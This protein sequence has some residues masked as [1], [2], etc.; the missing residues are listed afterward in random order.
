MAQFQST[1]RKEEAQYE[2]SLKPQGISPFIASLFGGGQ[3]QEGF[4]DFLQQRQ[5][6]AGQSF[7]PERVAE[8][9][10]EFNQSAA[11]D[12]Q[13]DIALAVAS[14]E[15]SP[16]V[17]EFLQANLDIS[18]PQKRAK[19]QS[20]VLRGQTVLRDVDRALAE[21]QNAGPIA[22]GLAEKGR[23]FTDRLSPAFE[24]QQH[25]SSIKSNISIDQLQQMREA[26]PT[27]G[28]LGQVP[29]QQQ[30]FLMSVL[31]SLSPSLPPEVLKENLNDVYNIYLDSM[32]G[33]PQELSVAVQQGKM[34]STQ[35]NAYLSSRKETAFNEFNLPS[36]RSG[37]QDITN[38]VIAPDGELVQLIQ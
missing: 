21:A 13:R 1:L 19:Q 22:G 10:T 5:E 20:A 37:G 9:R 30:E 17:A 36:A 33:S 4:E 15:V 29:V 27:G 32:F 35:A 11:G 28:A 26:S 25:L 7:T 38:L 8:L 2:A 34:S 12:P 14:G 18:S 6:E 16:Q 23:L 31:G 24:L 3:T